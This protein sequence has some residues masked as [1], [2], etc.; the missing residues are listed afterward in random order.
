[1]AQAITDLSTNLSTLESILT[2]SHQESTLYAEALTNITYKKKIK[3]LAAHHNILIT[4]LYPK[5][6]IIARRSDP[7][8]I[9]A[10]VALTK[11][12]EKEAILM[13]DTNL[14]EMRNNHFDFSIKEGKEKG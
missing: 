14:V 10:Q 11:H 8:L 5:S 7:P 6:D 4:W 3:D 9:T 13:K 2:K 12:L 1:M